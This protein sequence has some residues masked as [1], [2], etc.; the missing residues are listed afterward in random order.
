MPAPDEQDLILRRMNHTQL[1]GNAPKDPLEVLWELVQM[2]H[3]LRT[4]GVQPL[5]WVREELEFLVNQMCPFDGRVV[6]HE[7]AEHRFAPAQ[8]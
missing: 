5:G 3:T 7:D 2:A 1:F 8:R 4:E 6:A